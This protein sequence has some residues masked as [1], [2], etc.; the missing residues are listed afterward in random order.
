MDRYRTKKI[1]KGRKEN[2]RDKCEGETH[3]K[4]ERKVYNNKKDNKM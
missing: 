4:R 1:D 2:K 3:S